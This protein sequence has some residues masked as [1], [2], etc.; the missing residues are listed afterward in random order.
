MKPCRAPR[1]V[2]QATTSEGLAEGPYV[3]A[4]VGFE[5]VTLQIQGIELTTEP[6][7]PYKQLLSRPGDVYQKA[8]PAAVEGCSRSC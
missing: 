8:L 6:L 5:P 7:G 4:R 3:A 1:H 2:I